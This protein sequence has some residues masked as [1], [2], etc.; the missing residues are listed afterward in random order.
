[1]T[2]QI[3]ILFSSFLYIS[4][5]F[6]CIVIVS[7]EYW[8]TKYI[9]VFQMKKR[10]VNKQLSYMILEHLAFFTKLSIITSLLILRVP[11]YSL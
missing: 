8:L 3:S 5:G 9:L 10:L 1:M 7:E 4:T 6:R 2:S 11:A